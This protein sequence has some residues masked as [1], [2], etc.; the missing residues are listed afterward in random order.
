MEGRKLILKER[1]KEGGVRAF[2]ND[3]RLTNIHVEAVNILYIVVL[4]VRVLEYFNERY[5]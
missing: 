4:C 5:V 1:E 2:S 3:G